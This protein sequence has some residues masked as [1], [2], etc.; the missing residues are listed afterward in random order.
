[1]AE[2]GAG[3]AGDDAEG[4]CGLTAPFER[5]SA[6]VAKLTRMIDSGEL[7]SALRQMM[8]LEDVRHAGR[9]VSAQDADFVELIAR[10]GGRPV[11]L[12]RLGRRQVESLHR[13]QQSGFVLVEQR[14]VQVTDRGRGLAAARARRRVASKTEL[15]RLRDALTKVP[16]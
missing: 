11:P 2:D 4:A 5:L 1:M 13:L 3:P 10:L 14:R 8:M 12:S 9:S 15:G 6:A 16:L 7:A